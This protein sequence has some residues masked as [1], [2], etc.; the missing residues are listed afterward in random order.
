ML[1]LTLEVPELPT[2]QE[3]WTVD[4]FSILNGKVNKTLFSVE[5]LKGTAEG[6]GASLT[7][8]DHPVAEEMKMLD[9]TMTSIGYE[10]SSDLRAILH[11]P[12]FL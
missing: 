2:G 12:I 11:K 9:I 10:Y 6:A 7:L 1:I 3:T 8:G 5:G 4:L